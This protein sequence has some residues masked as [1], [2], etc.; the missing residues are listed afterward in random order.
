MAEDAETITC[1]KCQSAIS[2]KAKV[3]PQCRSRVRFDL[4][5]TMR[6]AG[7]VM[8]GVLALM[9]VSYFLMSR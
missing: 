2:P 9:V 3:C 6:I 4:E 1:P 7:W 5:H 8:V